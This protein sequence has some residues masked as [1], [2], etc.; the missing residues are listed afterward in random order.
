MSKNRICE[1][2]S[3]RYPII[4]APMTWLSDANLAAAVSKGGGLGVL[5]PNAGARTLTTD[6]KETAERL[7]HQIRLTKSLTSRPF[8]VNIM[9]FDRDVPFSDPCVQ[10]ILEEEVPVAVTCGDRPDRY[11]SQLKDAG[12]KVIHRALTANNIEAAKKAEQAGVDAFVAVGFE[13]GGHVGEDAIPTFV[14]VPQIVDALK[15][16]VIAGGGIAD[17]RGMAAAMALGAEGIFM[18][19]RFIATMECPAHQSYK[20]A[21][22]NARDTSTITVPGMVAFCRGFK[23]PPVEAYSRLVLKGKSTPEDHAKVFSQ[24]DVPWITGNWES[25]M[26]GAGAG[27]GLIKEIKSAADVIKDIVSQAEKIRKEL[28][29]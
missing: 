4:Q 24:E 14:L 26:F 9:V 5:G 23:T 25:A 16:P 17:G 20:Q 29:R 13:G 10:V 12:V 3:I 11:I 22:I 6:V 15:I 7:R 2:L 19:T 1:L 8:G 28:P 21:I 27:A 18:G